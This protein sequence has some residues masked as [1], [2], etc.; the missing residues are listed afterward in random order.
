MHY[1]ILIAAALAAATDGGAYLAVAFGNGRIEGGNASG[2]TWMR[3]RT[4]EVRAGRE[5][6]LEAG[7]AVRTDFVHYNEGH[8]D[9][10]H[11]DGFALQWVAVRPLGSRMTGELAAGPYLSMNTTTI[12]G[13]QIDDAHLGVLFTGALRFPLPGPLGT[14]VRLAYHHVAMHYVHGSDAVVLGVGRQFG[15]ARHDPATDPGAS[16]WLGASAGSSI[17]NMAGTHGAH[18][19]VLEARQYGDHWGVGAKFLFE[20]DDGAR[21]DRRGLALQLWYLQPVTPSLAMGAAIGP[22]VAENRRDDN[23]TATNAAIT[24]QAERALSRRTRAFINF[25]RIKTF[26][27]TNDRDLFQIGLL[28]RFYP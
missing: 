11:R 3:G 17:T 15:P 24:F 25:N 14:H 20:G 16:L 18:A 22:Y 21:V 23:R 10:N 4:F 9:N 6:D 7:G 5:R 26:R 12:A 27:N 13:R 28:R 1:P 2:N 19:A 8:P